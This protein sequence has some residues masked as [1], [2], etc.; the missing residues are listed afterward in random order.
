MIFNNLNCDIILLFLIIDKLSLNI[1][2]IQFI[3]KR[4]FLL[5]AQKK[6]E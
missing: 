5:S 6:I 2:K 3:Q 4:V 1:I